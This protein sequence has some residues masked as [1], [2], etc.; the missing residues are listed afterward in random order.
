M[1]EVR[2]SILYFL[3]LVLGILF[4]FT[5]DAAHE[6]PG[7]FRRKPLNSTQGKSRSFALVLTLVL[8]P[9]KADP[10]AEERSCKG[11]AIGAGGAGGIKVILTL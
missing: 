6:S 10:T 11:F 2:R 3:L 5:P 9:T 1:L 4:N 7:V 8:V